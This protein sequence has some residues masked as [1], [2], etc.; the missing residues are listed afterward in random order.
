[1]KIIIDLLRD[2][3]IICLSLLLISITAAFFEAIG[4]ALILPFLSTILESNSETNQ[5]GLLNP[6]L[7]FI[8]NIQLNNNKIIFFSFT[9]LILFVLKNSLIYI[10]QIL[11][12]YFQSDI[13][14]YLSVKILNQYH[15][16]SILD[17]SKDSPGKLL[18]NLTYE[19]LVAEKFFSRSIDI[20]AKSLICLMIYIVLILAN[21]K[22]TLILSFI[23]LI[24]FFVFRLLFNNLIKY[25]GKKRLKI[26]QEISSQGEL[27]IRSIRDIKLLRLQSQTKSA[28]NAKYN[29]LKTI[30]LKLSSVQNL[31]LP[32]TE[33]IIVFSAIFFI[34]YIEIYATV[35][36]VEYVPLLGFILVAAQRLGSNLSN[37]LSSRIL[38]VS[39]LP[40]LK[41]I[42]EIIYKNR[43]SSKLTKRKLEK[44]KIPINVGVEELIL[45]NISISFSK[46]KKILDDI[47]MKINKNQITAI[48][49]KSGSG[50]STLIDIICGFYK[51]D[52]G[53][54]SDGLNNISKYNIDEWRKHI[55]VVS[56]YSVFF[57]G[58][59]RSNL[60]LGNKQ[61]NEDDINNAIRKSQSFEF[62]EALPDGIDTE[63]DLGDN[64]L[65]SGQYQRLAI[66]RA[67]LRDAKLIILDEATN[68][69][70]AKTE[71][72]LMVEL[73]KMK[74][75]KTI[76]MITH[77]IKNSVYADY[78]YMIESGRI[79][80]E[81]GTNDLLK[82]EDFEKIYN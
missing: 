66:A 77:N 74:Y 10:R 81:G 50:K 33:I 70:D 71:N 4:I 6:L 2:H 22:I 64:K 47:S 7:E 75:E 82:S 63:I 69:L 55:S 58:T 52:E 49:G 53:S 43:Y 54:I 48:I 68:H 20:I 23:I 56:S 62:I 42:H 57:P 12:Q 31:P 41:L 76:I 26:S 78:F 24:F 3:K 25:I 28:F 32:L 16:S 59:I 9:I 72:N 35:S 36:I 60:I 15:S 38:I 27:S 46:G 30:F 37:I 65:S 80:K 29:H 51:Q 8:N 34:L 39:Y 19:P 1:M 61:C 17:L 18:N 73:A 40:S 79:S 13:R 44:N 21:F 67:L 5:L 11:T 45:Q 14:Q